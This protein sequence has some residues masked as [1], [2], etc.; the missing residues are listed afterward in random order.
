M[1]HTYILY[2]QTGNRYYVGYCADVAIRLER[3]NSGSVT[4]T[5]PYIPYAL[6]AYKSFQTKLEAMREEAR[7]KKKKSRKYL[8]YLIAGNW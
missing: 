6:K 1:F 4:A 8:E 5:K 3:H 7:L 2:S